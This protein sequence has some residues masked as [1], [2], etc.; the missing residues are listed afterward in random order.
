MEKI[1]HDSDVLLWEDYNARTGEMSD[2]EEQF[3]GSNG[4]LDILLPRDKM[5]TYNI[6]EYMR[7]AGILNRCSMDSNLQISTARN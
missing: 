2:F 1:S 3:W 6:I 7:D 5:E 4:D